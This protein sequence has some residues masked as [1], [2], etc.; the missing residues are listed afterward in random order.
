MIGYV[1]R[2]LLQIVPVL[3]GITLVAFTVFYFTPGDPVALM[4]GEIGT[5]EVEAQLR[6]ALG[7]DQPVYV[8]YLRFLGGLLQGDLGTS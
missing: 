2:R 5:P 8:Q 3:F 6:T 7:L 4:L 1:I